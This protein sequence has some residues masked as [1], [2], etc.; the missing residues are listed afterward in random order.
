MESALEDKEGLLPEA[1]RRQGQ[2][3]LINVA[4]FDSV[5]N[6]AIG[7]FM[8]FLLGLGATP[9]QIGAQVALVQMAPLWQFAGLQLLP[10]VGKAR[11]HMIGR[12]GSV[13]PLAALAAVAAVGGSSPGVVWL[14][15]GLNSLRVVILTIGATGWWPL[16]QDAT[17]GGAVGAFFARLRTR[18]RAFDI[19]LPVLAGWYLGRHPSSQRFIALF[20]AAMAAMSVAAWLLRIVPERP[21]IPQ[22]NG[23]LMRLGDALGV[24]S[25]RR[26]L[27]F[28]S[29]RTFVATLSTSFWVVLLT[30]N[31]VPANAMVW[32]GAVAA[33]GNVCGLQRW[34]RLV[35]DHGSR[36]ALAITILPQALIGLAF[37]AFPGRGPLLIWWA[38]SFYLVWGVF[39]GG[40]LMG[41]T[42]A[43]LDAV[44]TT[45]QAEGFALVSYA[46]GLGGM[47]GGFLGGVLFQQATAHSQHV[48]GFDSRTLYLAGVHL[49]FLLAWLLSTRLSGHADQTPARRLVKKALQ[50]V[51]PW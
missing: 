38:V 27:A 42:R 18:L 49:C 30:A 8:L 44:P 32:F 35:D 47:A 21:V 11:L 43:M 4:V 33:F 22:E 3:A 48:L 39:E 40:Y 24:R 2:A 45:I 36:A 50:R 51:K 16:L 12:L 31:G 10:R 41:Q 14:A 13:V 6:A 25:L 34:G 5:K 46:S 1:E 7:P 28:I 17:A 19:V 9:F 20:V 26:F 37:L 29:A 15:I 23:L